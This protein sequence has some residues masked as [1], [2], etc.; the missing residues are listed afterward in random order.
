MNLPAPLAAGVATTSFQ[1]DLGDYWIA[2]GNVAAGVWKRCRDVLY[3]RVYRNAAYTLAA[4]QTAIPWDTVATDN[5]GMWSSANSTR[6]TPPVPGLWLL[7]TH[8]QVAGVAVGGWIQ[9]YPLKNNAQ[10]SGSNITQAGSAG[11][12][13]ILTYSEPITT[14]AGDYITVGTWMNSGLAAAVGA[15]GVYATFTYLGTG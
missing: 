1:D 13:L 9:S 8:I 4:A 12:T 3:L 10:A 5:Y 2:N 6:F 15:N 7:Q 11:S 14:A